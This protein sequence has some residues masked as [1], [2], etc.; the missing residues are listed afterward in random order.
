VQQHQGPAPRISR[1]PEERAGYVLALPDG[2]MILRPAERPSQALNSIP[3]EDALISP[4]VLLSNG[5]RP[6]DFARVLVDT[7]RGRP[8]VVEAVEVA[9]W[10]PDV[11][12]QRP[13]FDNMTPTHPERLLTLERPG[14]LTARLLDLFAPLGFGSRALVVSPPKAGKTTILREIAL[15]TIENFPDVRLICCLVGERPE[16]ATEF[17]R[18][19]PK[20]T[21]TGTPVEVVATTFDDV[22]SRHAALA[23]LT[24]E[25]A[26]RLVEG[27]Q[28][29]V[30]IVDSITRLV[31]A[32]N[33][34]LGRRD[35][36]RTLSGGMAAGAIAPSR[37]FFGAARAMQEGPSLTVVASCLVNTG[38]RQDDVVYE[39]L[40]GTGNSEIV[41][42]R[43]LAERR[44]FPALNLPATGTRREELLLPHERL[45]A[46]RKVRQVFAS[47]ENPFQAMNRLIERL[48]A[49]PDNATFLRNLPGSR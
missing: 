14:S 39:E 10:R 32:Y 36:G 23:D 8:Q 20:E 24:A 42:D 43:K 16:E 9:G 46:V 48:E 35:A 30:L 27:G 22:L 1:P 41:L 18:V 15:S 45:D 7:S 17:T 37:R 31:R 26:R 12:A 21:K 47:A 33:L 19:L 11:A 5:L 38:S 3:G 25:R 6:G 40:K 28:D 49:T 44:I 29:V 4:A 2:R 34:G 13:R